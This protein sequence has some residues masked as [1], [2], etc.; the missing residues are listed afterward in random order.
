MQNHVDLD[1]AGFSFEQVADSDSWSRARWATSIVTRLTGSLVLYSGTWSADY[2][3][4]LRINECRNGV[5]KFIR[6]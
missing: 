1:L 3:G 5:T 4:P 6:S 2:E